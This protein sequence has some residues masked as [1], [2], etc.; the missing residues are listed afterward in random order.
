MTSQIFLL[1]TQDGIA[2]GAIYVLVA[3]AL[4]LVFSVTRVIFVPQGEFI[5]YGA[6]TLAS[7]EAGALPMTPW[8]VLGLGVLAW[9]LQRWRERGDRFDWRSGTVL[10]LAAPAAALA[11]VHGLK[12]WWGNEAV[13]WLLTLGC[14]LPL[15]PILYHLVFR[16]IAGASTLVLLI[17]AISLH[18]ALVGAGLVM[19]G[20]EGFR[21][22]RI[23][24][25]SFD[26]LSITVLWQ[27]VA[28]LAVCALMIVLLWLFSGHTLAG[29]A[30]RASAVCARGARIVGIP[31]ERSGA[32]AFAIAGALGIVS[33]LL[34]GATTTINYESGFLLGLKGFVGAIIGGL[35]GFPLAAA[36]ALLVGLLEAFS[37]FYASQYKEI[38]VFALL[39]P[40][41]LWR[42]LGAAG[43]ADEEEA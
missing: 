22:T 24:D 39:L 41:L 31:V 30:L 19:F 34:I 23:V 4:V 8:L 13:R 14:L 1:L 42:S 2:S 33:G 28:V 21:T 6:L 5:A 20:A 10:F 29:K 32:T 37:S 18:L 15:A 3:L 9:L 36:G 17:A 25:G 40:V 12:P 11:A 16:P 38:V 27:T 7:L 35:A 43:H 26:W